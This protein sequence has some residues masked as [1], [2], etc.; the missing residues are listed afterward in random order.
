MPDSEKRPRILRPEIEAGRRLIVISDVHGNLPYL[1]GVL[2]KAGFGGD[3]LILFLGDFLEKGPESLSTLHAVM[4]LCQRGQA[5]AL[6]G[7]CDDWAAIFSDDDGG[8]GKNPLSY[9]QWRECGLLW[10][11]ALALGEDPAQLRD[12]AAFRDRIGKRFPDEFAFLAGLPHAMEAGRY[13]FAHAGLRP[14]IPL[15]EQNVRELLK[16]DAFY[17]RGYSFDKWVVVGHYPVVLYGDEI[18]CANPLI[19]RQRHIVNLDGGCVLKDDGQLN[20]LLIPDLNRDEFTW[21]AYDP[22]PLARVKEE[23]AASARSAYIRWGD[24][25]VEVLERGEEFSRCRHVRTGYE[26]DILTRYLFEDGRYTNCNDCTDYVLPLQRG[27]TVSVV[28]TCSR[29]YFVKHEGVSGWYFG[30]L[31]R[32]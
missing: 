26:L 25:K 23:Q 13:V 24:S 7:N 10:D 15:E 4:R 17:R 3:D 32:R 30:E 19:D 21:T 28:E 5:I 14:G 22:F 9:M 1:R 18:V 11:M 31:E 6:M 2:E 8:W 12:F 29:G 20:A 27:D 16:C